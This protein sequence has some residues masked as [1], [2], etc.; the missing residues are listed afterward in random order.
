MDTDNT[1]G[2]PEKPV[3][4]GAL[5]PVP[6]WPVWVAI[7]EAIAGA[8][9]CSLHPTAWTYWMIGGALQLPLI[10]ALAWRSAKAS[11]LGYTDP[12]AFTPDATM[13]IWAGPPG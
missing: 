11:K 7:P 10:G 12:T 5:P 4:E 9:L 6:M 2:M 13:T 1:N 3:D 8:L